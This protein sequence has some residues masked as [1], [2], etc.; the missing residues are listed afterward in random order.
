MVFAIFLNGEVFNLCGS[1]GDDS[2]VHV[3]ICGNTISDS[4]REEGR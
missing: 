3:D 4:P 2:I 1:G